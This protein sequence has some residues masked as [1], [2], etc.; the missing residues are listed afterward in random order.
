MRRLR[1]ALLASAT[2]SLVVLA[3]GCGGSGGG[4]RP[5]PAGVRAQDLVAFVPGSDGDTRTLVLSDTVSG[6]VAFVDEMTMSDGG[7]LDAALWSPDHTKLAILFARDGATSVGVHVLDPLTGTLTQV[8]EASDPADFAYTMAWSPDGSRLAYIHVLADVYRLFVVAPDGTGRVEV[9]G[10]LT[11]LASGV[12]SFAWAPDGSHIAMHLYADDTNEDGVFVMRSD[13]TNRVNVSGTIVPGGS[14]Q[15]LLSWSPDG[16][17]IAFE[18]DIA[19]DG[20]TEIFSAPAD[21][22]PR[23]R[24]HPVLAAGRDAGE[25]AWAPDSSRI[26]YI[27]DQTT[28]NRF[29]LHTSLAD[30]TGSLRVSGALE[31]GRQIDGF[32]WAPDSSR[33]AYVSDEATDDVFELFTVLPDGTGHVTASGT[34]VTGGRVHTFGPAFAWSP[35]STR[36]AYAADQEVDDQEE[37]YVTGP[38]GSPVRVSDSEVATSEVRSLLWSPDG[39]RLAFSGNLRTAGFIEIFVLPAVGPA[40]PLLAS[41]PSDSGFQLPLAWTPDGARLVVFSDATFDDAAQALVSDAGDGPPSTTLFDSPFG[42][43]QKFVD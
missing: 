17:R 18:G 34:M 5:F 15:F 30:G 41:A 3:T 21:G 31:S 32:A 23:L 10:P 40:V 6:A 37:V 4:G 36:I 39:S 33:V 43:Q 19:T 26:A 9:T 16:S 28:D 7:V 38:T 13:G 8:S 29:E 22:G 27:A 2:L 42:I 11:P 35:D 25:F 20:A 1:H 24:M 14:L 12:G